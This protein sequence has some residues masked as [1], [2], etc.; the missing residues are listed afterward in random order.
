MRAFDA[1]TDRQVKYLPVNG[2]PDTLRTPSTQ[3]R[4]LPGTMITPTRPIFPLNF[5][6][7]VRSIHFDLQAIVVPQQVKC[8]RQAVSFRLRKEGGHLCTG[9]M[10]MEEGKRPIGGIW[11]LP[12]PS[13]QNIT[14]RAILTWWG[15]ILGQSKWAC[16]LSS[17]HRGQNRCCGLRLLLGEL[18]NVLDRGLAK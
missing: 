8:S 15:V 9:V 1:F 12:E 2:P 3:P 4:R 16:H 18:R 17:V 13:R 11:V 7:L 14:G 6:A 10:C 5:P